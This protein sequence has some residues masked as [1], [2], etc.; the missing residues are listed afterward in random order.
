MSWK[1]AFTETPDEDMP[2]APPA[3]IHG[4]VHSW[5]LDGHHD[6]IFTPTAA[7]MLRV[8]SGQL[9]GC[10]LDVEDITDMSTMQ[11]ES[12]WMYALDP[13]VRQ[14]P[15]QSY[16]AGNRPWYEPN[17][18][19]TL[20]APVPFGQYHNLV[21]DLENDVNRNRPLGLF[22]DPAP[23]HNPFHVHFTMSTHEHYPE[24]TPDVFPVQY[25]GDFRPASATPLELSDLV[26]ENSQASPLESGSFDGAS[27]AAFLPNTLVPGA[28]VNLGAGRARFTPSAAD[29]IVNRR[30][31]LT[32]ESTRPWGVQRILTY[33][34]LDRKA[35]EYGVPLPRITHTDVQLYCNNGNSAH[36]AI[37]SVFPPCYVD[38]RL[39]GGVEVS[40]EELLTFFPYHLKWNDMVYRLAQNG[41]R[42]ADMAKYINYSRSLQTD[43]F[44]T[45]N[46]VSYSLIAADAAILNRKK[47]DPRRR[48][49][50]KTT[51]FTTNGWKPHDGRTDIGMI[52][53]FLVDLAAGVSHFPQGKG[54]RLLTRAVRLAVT[55]GHD[56]IRLSDLKRYIR[57]NFLIFPPLTSMVQQMV[58]AQHPDTAALLRFRDLLRVASSVDAVA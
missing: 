46:A 23:V 3:D 36:H 32:R 17:P 19:E 13:I 22:R 58:V 16:H 57:I 41:W 10:S 30:R 54:A 31:N 37:R 5:I 1:N 21:I 44:M 38:I 45:R 39:M 24:Q 11:A 52:D 47:G 56:E 50:W 6:F 28:K 4:S 48:K 9:D 35:R 42:P 27:G 53:Y 15:A 7:E 26:A 2:D 40:A 12:L 8:T 20:V 43:Q 29:L 51:C 34:F 49:P 25:S 55:R 14:R 18:A 33:Q